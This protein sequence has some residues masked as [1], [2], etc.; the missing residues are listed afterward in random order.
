MY[1]VGNSKDNSFFLTTFQFL[2]CSYHSASNHVLLSIIAHFFDT[3]KTAVIMI[4][5]VSTSCPCESGLFSSSHKV[6]SPFYRRAKCSENGDELCKDTIRV[7]IARWTRGVV[8][9]E[10][11]RDFKKK[12]GERAS[13]AYRKKGQGWR[14]G[15]GWRNEAIQ[16]PAMIKAGYDGKQWMI[17]MQYFE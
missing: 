11:L 17:E 9:R 10:W 7:S 1:I 13:K 15:K 14:M 2:S 12:Q 16:K 4:S 8:G 5:S 6:L 3:R